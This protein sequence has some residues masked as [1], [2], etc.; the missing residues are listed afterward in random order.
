[1]DHSNAR[2]ISYAISAVIVVLVLLWRIRRL[3]S[4]RR[5][6]LEWLWVL[7]AL[8]LLAAAA[9]LAQAPPI[10]LEWVWM[11]LAL[12]PARRSAGIAAG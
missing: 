1:L 3:Q 7:P 2:L 6:R 11:A 9:S 5:L 10:G 4:G 12:A 8:L